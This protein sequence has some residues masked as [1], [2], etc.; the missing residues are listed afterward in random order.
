MGKLNG[1]VAVVTGASKGIGAG[2]AK[3]LASEG[4]AVAVNY[5]SDA[6]GAEKVV[7]S[8]R[9]AGGT[10]IA[11]HGNVASLED[12]E[13]VLET[14]VQQLGQPDILVNNAGIFAFRPLEQI[15]EAH[16]QTHF[17][18]NV[19]GPILAS[20][21]A[22]RYFGDRGGSIINISSLV[23]RTPLAGSTVYSAT[24]AALDAVTKSLSKELGP[25]GIRVNSIQPGMVVTEGSSAGGFTEGELRRGIEAATPLGRIGQPEDIAGA[26]VFFAS[27]DSA[28]IT[29]ETLAIAG[30]YA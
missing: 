14:T 13:Q 19:L 29:G 28:W 27:D 10:A 16:F 23:S 7:Q 26:A 25:R 20:Q 30:G 5:A 21:A 8:I 11:V 1:K 9:E 15:D 22:L 24:K 3:G 12:L 4:A 18:V 6:A 2:I 17:N